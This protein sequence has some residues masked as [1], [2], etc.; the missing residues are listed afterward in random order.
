[1]EEEKRRA[2]QAASEIVEDGMTVALG[3]GT[4]AAYVLP[5]LAAQELSLRCVV[6]WPRTKLAA[7]KL[8]LR[9]EPFTADRLDI[10][11]DGADPV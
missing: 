4:K 5:A 10:M 8:G 7:A 11:I 1:M 6:R 2:A 3:T 9:L